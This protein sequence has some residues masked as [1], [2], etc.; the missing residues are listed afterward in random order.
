MQLLEYLRINLNEAGKRQQDTDILNE[1]GKDGWELMGI[2]PNNMAYLKRPIPNQLQAAP[3][4]E[5]P[6]PQRGAYR[7]GAY[8]RK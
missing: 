2:L 3:K 1:I 6:K 8:T 5:A 4:P 7:R